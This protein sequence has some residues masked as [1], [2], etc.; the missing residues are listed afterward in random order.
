MDRHY[1]WLFSKLSGSDKLK[2]ATKNC[3]YQCLVV[4][5]SQGHHQ[6]LKLLML[7]GSCRSKDA[8]KN[9]TYQELVDVSHQHSTVNRI[10]LFSGGITRIPRSKE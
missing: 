4:A 6:E 1:N 3:S 8:T 2:D 10:T 5:T 7:S 9:W